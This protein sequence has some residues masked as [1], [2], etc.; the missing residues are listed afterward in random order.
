MFAADGA[1]GL[2]ASEDGVAK[3]RNA[4]KGSARGHYLGIRSLHS[5]QCLSA[6]GA[7]VPTTPGVGA[8]KIEMPVPDS[9]RGHHLGMVRA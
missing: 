4:C 8:A 5:L 7:T 2:T 6:G 9:A 3:T 1:T